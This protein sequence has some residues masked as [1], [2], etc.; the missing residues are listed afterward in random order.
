M[1][2]GFPDD[3]LFEVRYISSNIGDDA[4]AALVDFVP[5]GNFDPIACAALHPV[6]VPAD[7]FTCLMP[8]SVFMDIPEDI[9]EISPFSLLDVDPATDEEVAR[10]MPHFARLTTLGN[11]LAARWRARRRPI[12]ATR[13]FFVDCLPL[14]PVHLYNVA[15]DALEAFASGSTARANR[16]KIATYCEVMAHHLATREQDDVADDHSEPRD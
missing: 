6:V 11:D 1:F 14:T 7:W 16:E 4:V 2:T 13:E 8:V 3:T 10:L 12:V 9:S 5:H 15:L